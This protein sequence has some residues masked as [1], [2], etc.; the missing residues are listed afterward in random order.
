[1]PKS[2]YGLFCLLIIVTLVACSSP[3]EE[4]TSAGV[5]AVPTD[6]NSG[7]PAPSQPEAV[8]GYP[9]PAT[10]LPKPLATPTSLLPE[11]NIADCGYTLQT[12]PALIQ[13]NQITEQFL[14]V[15]TIALDLPFRSIQLVEFLPM[16]EQLLFVG[17]IASEGDGIYLYDIS[18]SQLTTLIK[19]QN[20]VGRPAW[21]GKEVAFVTQEDTNLIL[22][23][24]EGDSTKTVQSDVVSPYLQTDPM[25]GNVATIL[26][27]ANRT[28]MLVEDDSKIESLLSSPLHKQDTP[29]SFWYA[30]KFAF[31]PDGNWFVQYEFDAFY[32]GDRQNNSICQIKLPEGSESGQ[33]FAY[34]A[35]WNPNSQQVALMIASDFTRDLPYENTQLAILDLSRKTITT[36]QNGSDGEIIKAVDSLLGGDSL[37]MQIDKGKNHEN[38]QTPRLGLYFADLKEGVIQPLLPEVNDFGNTFEVGGTIVTANNQFAFLCIGGPICLSR[39]SGE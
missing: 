22:K 25:T 6:P 24:T 38:V 23:T 17:E 31:S 18:N 16:T 4:P 37:L 11:N 7:Y 8:V 30:P 33:T 14:A 19:G 1:M 2:I 34:H 27:E 5:T 35:S 20:I 3:A 32:I 10:E 29:S 12:A 26:S 21:N 9:P 15:E 36:Y 39:S 28:V 13:T